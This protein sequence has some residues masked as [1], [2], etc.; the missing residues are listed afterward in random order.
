MKVVILKER[1]YEKNL[2]RAAVF[3]AMMKRT[4]Q[5]EKGGRHDK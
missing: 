2:K 3:R 4:R 1:H 5:G